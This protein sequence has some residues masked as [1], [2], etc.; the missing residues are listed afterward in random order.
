M[1]IAHAGFD[2]PTGMPFWPLERT[3]ILIRFCSRY[4]QI[5]G[6]VLNPEFG[7]AY[8]LFEQ[9]KKNRVILELLSS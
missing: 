5:T 4:R 8:D 2:L 7:Q 3:E 9:M 1:N 6:W